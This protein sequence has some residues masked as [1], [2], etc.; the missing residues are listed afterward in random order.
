MLNLSETSHIIMRDS[1]T[2]TTINNALSVVNKEKDI[3]RENSAIR[4]VN[5]G[6]KRMRIVAEV[7]SRS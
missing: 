5:H 2:V 6:R 3:R 1:K 7:S 4:I